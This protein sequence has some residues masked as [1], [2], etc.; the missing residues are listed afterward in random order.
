MQAL[1]HCLRTFPKTLA[2]FVQLTKNFKARFF[3]CLATLN[4]GQVF[5]HTCDSLLMLSHLLI[6]TLKSGSTTIEFVLEALGRRAC[7]DDLVLDS[8][9]VGLY[10]GNW[11]F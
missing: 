5:F 3:F 6:A 1:E 2:L 10:V 4:G 9:A 8:G 11:G 7:S